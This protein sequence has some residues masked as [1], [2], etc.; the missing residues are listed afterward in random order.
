MVSKL[1]VCILLEC[2]LV[3]SAKDIAVIDINVK[4]LGK[5]QIISFV[6]FDCECETFTAKLTQMFTI[7]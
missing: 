3:I 1:V 6:S 5:K 2:C 4:T 7:S